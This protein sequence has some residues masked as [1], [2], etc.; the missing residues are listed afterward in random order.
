MRPFPR[1]TN[2]PEP[3]EKLIVFGHL[4]MG[5]ALVLNGLY[6]TLAATSKSLILLTDVK[7]V[8]DV[9]RLYEDFPQIQVLGALGYDDIRS[10]WIPSCLDA[11]RLGFF[12]D[13]GFNL[14][15]WDESFYHGLGVN[16]NLRWSAFQLPPSL[17]LA[18]PT[19]KDKVVLIH[20]DPT[21][22]FTIVRQLLP[23]GVKQVFVTHRPSFWDWMPEMLAAQEVH[24]ID[25]SYLNLAESL[26]A[27]GYLRNTKLVWHKYAKHYQQAG[28][29]QMRAPWHIFQ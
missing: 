29:P 4:E 12:A 6:R 7:F 1:G 11:K 21:R 15:R 28:P 17:R 22:K 25:S 23:A 18:E 5:D 3:P 14:D 20:E 10:R 9:R 8:N 26:Y 2:I 24:C 16:F 27:L 19:R 13:S